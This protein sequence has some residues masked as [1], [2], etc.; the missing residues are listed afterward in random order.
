MHAISSDARCK[1]GLISIRCKTW[2]VAHFLTDAQGNPGKPLR[3]INNVLGIMRDGIVPQEVLD[4]NVECEHASDVATCIEQG[5]GFVI[6]ETPARRT[7]PKAVPRHTLKDCELAANMFDHPSWVAYIN[8]TSSVELPFDACRKSKVPHLSAFKATLWLCTPDIYPF[9]VQQFGTPPDNLCN[10][11]PG[12]HKPLRG[13][14]PET[15]EYM[16][17]ASKSENYSGEINLAIATAVK[18]WCNAVGEILIAAVAGVIRGK[19]LPRHAIT[20]DLIHDC[21]NHDEARV[22]RHL[23]HALCDMPEWISKMI[24]EKPCEACLKGDAKRLGPTG[25]LPTDEG[26]LFIDAHH[27]TVPEI[28]TGRTVTIGATHAATRFSKSARVNGKG[29]A[30]LAIELILAY[31]N[32]VH[33]PITWIHTDN[34]GELKGTKVVALCRSKNIRITTT[35]VDSSRK[36]PQEPKWRVQMACSRKYVEGGKAP[37]NFT[38]WAWDHAEEGNNL[39]P[40]RE[41]PHDCALGRLLSTPTKTVKPPGSHRRP[42]FCLC[43]PTIAPRLP[44]GTLKNKHAAQSQRAVCLGY[45]GGASGAFETVGTSHTQAGYACYLPDPDGASGGSILVTSDVS[46]VPTCFPG[47]TRTSKGGWTISDASINFLRRGETEAAVKHEAQ[48]EEA[49]LREIVHEDDVDETTPEREQFPELRRGFPP[50]LEVAD[51]PTDKAAGDAAGRGGDDEPPGRGGDEPPSVTPTTPPAAPTRFIVPSANWPDYPC[52]EHNGTGWEVQIIRREKEWARCKFIN[53]RAEDGRPFENM[54]LRFADLTPLPEVAE[55]FSRLAPTGIIPASPVDADMQP[56]GTNEQPSNPSDFPIPNVHSAP[57]PGSDDAIRDPVRP[58]RA[59]RPPDRWGGYAAA[60]LATDYEACRDVHFDI[61]SS[62]LPDSAFVVNTTDGADRLICEAFDLFDGHGE[63]LMLA[64][65][66]MIRD[67]YNATP[68]QLQRALMIAVDA[69]QVLLEYGHTSP[70]MLMMRELYAVAA[71]E[72]AMQGITVPYFESNVEIVTGYCSGNNVTIDQIFDGN[73]SGCI[74]HSG[75]EMLGDELFAVAKAKTSP[76]T[77]SERQMRGT[78]WDTPKQLEVAKIERLNAKTDVSA[79]D[80]TIQGMPIS[81]MMWV[82]RRK[83]LADGSVEKDN[84]RCVA[85][86][87]LDKSKYNITPNDTTS[88]TAR[89]SSNLAFDAVACLRGQHKCDYDVPGAYLQGCQREH[90]RRLYRPPVGWRKHDERG[91]EILWLSNSPFY[92]ATD[93]GAIWNRTANEVFTSN[94]PPHGCGLLRCS[95]EPS[96]YAIKVSEQEGCGQVNNTLYVDDGR[97]A[98]DDDKEATAKATEVQAK[99][100]DRFGIKFGDNNPPETK[101]LSA[102]IIT[103]DCRRVVSVRAKS[104]IDLQVKRYADGDVSISK[105]FPA[106]WSYMPADET[107]VRAFEAASA[108]RTPASEELTKRYGSLFGALLHA[109]KFRPEIS[110]ALG[111]CGS[112]LTFPTEELYECLMHVLVY[113]GRSP[114][115][116]TTYSAYAPNANKL[117]AYADSNWATTRSVTGYLIMLAGAAII[118]ASRRQHCI[119]MSSCEAEL[120]ALADLAIE[121]LHIVEVVNFLGHE[122]PDAIEACTDSK[123]AYDLC[124][125]Y[126]SA[127]NSRHVDRK[128]FKMRELRGAGRVVVKHIP[129]ETN[130]ADLFTKILPRQTFEKHRKTTLNLPGDTGIEHARRVRTEARSASSQRDGTSK[131]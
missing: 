60:A 43:Y 64:D 3:D 66:R 111:L 51:A 28:F 31:F 83:R 129:G 63:V 19:V 61:K 73:Y 12:T 41:P 110:A 5:G 102:N 97:L 20:H 75:D 101:F 82:G 107:L 80:E 96:V 79:D 30:H 85:R 32:S 46:F 76:D 33:R 4:S 114:N 57:P 17:S 67:E 123:A 116:G 23:H 38:A 21:F 29:D 122:T 105:R 68:I 104:Y 93:A 90:E 10:H 88:P 24:V 26:L 9:M 131:P 53:A 118:A 120:V 59:R 54:W 72:A 130:P 16:T 6:A 40:S 125:R 65:E 1:G 113:L 70:Q 35:T 55:Q 58:E 37:Y 119:T 115:L 126:T 124:H 77:F 25:S 112:C 103:S 78:E 48:T 92:G 49:A 15:G 13:V 87:D 27:V 128:L 50:E 52:T 117:I 22:L 71:L 95:N 98:W 81:E 89:T 11:P 86:G 100:A 62:K 108:T 34:A 42:W 36:N 2:S 44:S 94:E 45:I 56:V 106:H 91:V 18:S 74:L 8:A 69:Q 39:R 127:A 47:L 14:D 121:L 7:G 99:L 109:A 84:A